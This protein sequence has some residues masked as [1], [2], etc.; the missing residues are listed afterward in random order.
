MALSLEAV[1]LTDSNYQHLPDGMT[2]SQFSRITKNDKKIHQQ[3]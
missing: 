1:Y 3:D 2:I